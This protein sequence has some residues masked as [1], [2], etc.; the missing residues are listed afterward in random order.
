[1]L[2]KL[3]LGIPV[4]LPLL[5]SGVGYALAYDATWYKT[6]FWAGE[7]PN[8]FTL[9]KDFTTEIRETPDPDAAHSVKC[10][11]KQGET[12]HQWNEGRVKASKLEFVSYVKKVA[13][14]I[15]QPATLILQNEKTESD[16]T[17]A[18]KAGDEWT[19][20]T[21][22][23]EGAFRM[24]FKGVPYAAEQELFEYSQEKGK[25]EGDSDHEDHEWLKLT[26]ANGNKGWLLFDD[27]AELP[28]F[29]KPDFPEYG[30]A[31]D[32]AK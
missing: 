16:E 23:A 28:E 30:K 2:R 29:E 32:R 4:A 20:L 11:L 17:I 1:M 8:G 25:K 14:E 15:K 19:Y 31:E 6:D 24:E 9:A 12:Y 27:V 26:C 22:Y 21:Y 18:F 10:A 7:Y 5:M 13:Y 3:I